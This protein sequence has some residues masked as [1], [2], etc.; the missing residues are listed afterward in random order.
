MMSRESSKG[1][2]PVT[3]VTSVPSER[4]RDIT[5]NFS[6]M[7]TPITDKFSVMSRSRSQGTEVTIV[8]VAFCIVCSVINVCISK[9]SRCLREVTRNI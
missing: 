5:E 7:G 6:I 2:A 3:I 9:V 4:E 1:N 8:T